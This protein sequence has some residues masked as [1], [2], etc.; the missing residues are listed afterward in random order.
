MSVSWKDVYITRWTPAASK[1]RIVAF[2]VSMRPKTSSLLINSVRSIP[3][4]AV[5]TEASSLKSN[6]ARVHTHVDQIVE[7]VWVARAGH[8]TARLDLD[9]VE[10]VVDDKTSE[11]ARA[12]VTRRC[13]S[14]VMA[15]GMAIA[16]CF[17]GCLEAGE[18]RN[19][20]SGVSAS[21]PKHVNAYVEISWEAWQALCIDCVDHDA[22]CGSVASTH[23]HWSILGSLMLMPFR[24]S[25]RPTCTCGCL[26][27]EGCDQDFR[28]HHSLS[29]CIS[30]LTDINLARQ[31]YLASDTG[32]IGFRHITDVQIFELA[33]Y[34]AKYYRCHS[35]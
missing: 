34:L 30:K 10:Q 15:T 12:P 19:G 35:Q 18:F 28:R 25:L 17:V 1:T 6:T 2:W 3:C 9:R 21:P 24:Q 14:W 5:S 8:N 32:Q 27:R 31:M 29:I 20:R 11:L 13:K 33:P 4:A 16:D 26:E 22:E 23:C 7:L